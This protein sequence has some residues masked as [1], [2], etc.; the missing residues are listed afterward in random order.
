MQLFEMTTTQIY[1]RFVNFYFI[2]INNEKFKFDLL[3]FL[4]LL[5]NI[6]LIIYYI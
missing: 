5:K 2:F 1:L 3:N 6:Y 4:I